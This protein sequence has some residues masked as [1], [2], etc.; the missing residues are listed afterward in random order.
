MCI[1]ID[2]PQAVTYPHP[3]II[4]RNPHS[5][6]MEKTISTPSS[7]KNNTAGKAEIRAIFANK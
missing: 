1:A 7:T 6:L 5:V 3:S 4:N 2:T